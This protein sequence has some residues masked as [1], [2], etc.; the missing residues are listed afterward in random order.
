MKHIETVPKKM[1][2][3]KK[4]PIKEYPQFYSNMLKIQAI[5]PTHELVIL[6]KFHNDR[7]KNA[8]F[9]KILDFKSISIVFQKF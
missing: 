1:R 4:M 6:A 8:N 9:L 3:A 5:S 2:L 7:A